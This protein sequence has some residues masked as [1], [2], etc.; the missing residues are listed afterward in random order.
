MVLKKATMLIAITAVLLLG[1]CGDQEDADEVLASDGPQDGSPEDFMEISEGFENFSVWI[2]TSD[3]PNRDSQVRGIYVFDDGQASSYFNISDK[4]TLEEVN[5]L[6]DEEIIEHAKGNADAI[7]KGEYTLDILLDQ[8]GQNT[9]EMNVLIGKYTN[10]STYDLESLYWES[11]L[12]S[13]EEYIASV[14]EEGRQF[15]INNEDIIFTTI[16]D[17]PSNILSINGEMILQTIFNTTYSGLRSGDHVS[18]LTRVD[19][20]FAGFTIDSPDSDNIRVTI[21]G[22]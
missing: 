10:I 20:S 16:E 12:S 7:S 13:E 5:D 2:E 6:T 11:G 15:E 9:S 8:F 17:E 19:E 3:T 4:L 1:G 22:E 21:E 18:L 14:E